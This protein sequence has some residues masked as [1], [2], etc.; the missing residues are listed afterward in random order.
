MREL[1]D[2]VRLPKES[3]VYVLART[4]VELFSDVIEPS[5]SAS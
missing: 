3:N 4:P 5:P 2:V 1:V